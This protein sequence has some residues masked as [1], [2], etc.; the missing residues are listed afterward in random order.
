VAD[1]GAAAEVTLGKIAGS[2]NHSLHICVAAQENS[3]RLCRP[4]PTLVPDGTDR[5]EF[6][7]RSRST[8]ARTIPKGDVAIPAPPLD[9]IL[10]ASTDPQRLHTWYVETLGGLSDP[11]GFLHFGPVAVLITPHGELGPR[12]TE[13]GRF[14]LNF[15]VDSIERAAAELDRRGV[16]WFAPVEYREDGGAWFGTVLDPDGN[17]VQLIE[18]TA[19]YWRLRRDRHGLAPGRRSILQD[20]S[21]ATRLPA[22]DLERARRFYAERLGLEPIDE[23]EGGLLYECGGRRFALFASTGRASGDHTQMGFTVPDLRAALAELRE[24]G[25]VLDDPP[26]D[27]DDQGVTAV[28]GYYP[29]YRVSGERAVWFHDSEGNLLGLSELVR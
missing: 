20:A 27:A 24:R 1:S 10:L 25:L 21:V 7:A 17:H 14:V 26:P 8:S 28:D 3:G 4:W 16:T 23:R 18:L 29:T 13:P 5:A 15:T 9:S 6:E 12:T 2:D 19:E 11:D 22:Q